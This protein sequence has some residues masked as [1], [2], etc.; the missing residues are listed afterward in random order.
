[1]KAV[2]LAIA[3]LALAAC[4]DASTRP[5]LGTVEQQCGAA[6]RPFEESW[7][8]VRVGFAGVQDGYPGVR[9][10]YLATGDVVAENVRAGQQEDPMADS[11]YKVVEVVGTSTKSLRD[12]RVAEVVE[13]DVVIEKGKVTSYRTKLKL[14]F[15]YEGGDA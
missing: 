9:D 12:L 15:K 7:P 14:S 5:N 3:L 6:N 11:V 4:E 1:M 10:Q 2:A 13:Q 8:C